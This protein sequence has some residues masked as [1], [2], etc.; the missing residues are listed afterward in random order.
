MDTE[1]KYTLE[2]DQIQVLQV[3]GCVGAVYQGMKEDESVSGEKH[4]EFDDLLS[5]VELIGQQ[6]VAQNPDPGDEPKEE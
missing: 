5:L 1:R 6:F 2:L 3:L 4:A